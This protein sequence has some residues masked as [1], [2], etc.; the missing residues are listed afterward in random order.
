MNRIPESLVCTSI[1]AARSDT[2]FTYDA[3]TGEPKDHVSISR[4]SFGWPQGKKEWYDRGTELLRK[5][6]EK[7]RLSYWYNVYTGKTRRE[8]GEDIFPRL[9]SK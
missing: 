5:A 1:C 7:Y 9:P 6:A 8:L 2:S 3:E 4:S